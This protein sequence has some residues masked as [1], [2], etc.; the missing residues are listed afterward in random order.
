[1]FHTGVF[2]ELGIKTMFLDTRYF[3]GFCQ[4]SRD[5]IAVATVH[6]NCCRGIQAKVIDLMA[7]FRDW[8]NYRGYID[9]Q[10]LGALYVLVWSL[11]ISKGFSPFQINQCAPSSKTIMITARDERNELEI[12]LEGASMKNKT[13]IIAMV[14]KAYVEEGDKTML[15]LFRDSFWLGE[16]TRS[17]LDH[18]LIVAMDQIAFDRC[19]LLHLHCY[20]LVMEGVD[21]AGEKLY[22]S[23]EFI[24][25][26]WRRTLFLTDVLKRGYSFI[27]TDTDV[28]WLRN[29]FTRLNLDEAEDVQISCD[30]F[31]GKQ[32]S[33]INPINTGFY[34]VRSNNKTIALFNTWYTMKDNSNYTGMKDQDVLVKM[35]HTGLF[36]ELG[37]RTRFLNTRYFSGFCE[38]S[39]DMRVVTTVHANCCR[40]IQAKVK[41]LAVTLRNWKK[42]RGYLEDQRLGILF[43]WSLS[44]SKGFLPFQ[45]YKWASS[46]KT[47]TVTNIYLRDELEVALDGASMENKTLII[48]MMNK[49]YVEGD[50]TMLNLFLDSFWLGENT[51]FLLDHL[52][53]VAVDET[54]FDRCKFLHLHCY[55]LVM[56]GVNSAGEKLYMSNEFIK[57]MWRR[58]Q[59]LYDVLKRGYSFIFTD[60]DI[61]WLRNPFTRLIPDEAKDIQISCDSNNPKSTPINTGF[62]FVQSNNKTIALF[63]T[64][65]TMKDNS[66]YTGMKDQDVLDKMLH[67]GL[68]TE[69][70]IR[71]RFLDT[72]YFS[73]FCQDSRDMMVVTTVHANCCRSIQAKVIDLTAVLQDW[74]KYRDFVDDQRLGK[75]PSNRTYGFGWSKHVAC[76][77][78]WRWL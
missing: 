63:N 1:M 45:K 50:K 33:K 11:S 57:M 22:M 34:Y 65:Y 31:N 42:Y 71:T 73:G 40:S 30:K 77:N 61:M 32:W 28:M 41:D 23:N 76:R 2:T 27:F 36:T 20:R 75:I 39:R 78:S 5:M 52:L 67:T 9:D 47:T 21:S 62:Y 18:V 37:I 49:A 7:V 66:N 19:N 46:S 16:N 68:F 54:A 24:N 6:A 59:F 10:R 12:A 14:N 13:L 29:P 64:W 58:T 4:D 56:D 69:F 35:L 43:I 17:L 8:K 25:M 60:A 70:G 53:I 44:V 38:D 72:R 3:S 26:M 51:R 55:R 48:V 15:D 74:K